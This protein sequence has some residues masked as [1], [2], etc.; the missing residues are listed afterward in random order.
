[1]RPL[2]SL[3][4]LLTLSLFSGYTTKAAEPSALAEPI[5]S[6]QYRKESI[7]VILSVSETNIPTS[8]KVQLMLD[9]HAPHDSEVFFP[10]I[11]PF[12]EPFAI[13]NGYAEPVQLLP[14]GKQLHRRVWELVP[15]LPGET[16]FQ[17]LE[18]QIGA[19]A[20]TTEPVAVNVTSLLPAE[21]S[22]LE[23]RD[24]SAPIA[25]LPKQQLKREWILKTIASLIGILLIG[26]VFKFR[27]RVSTIGVVPPYKAALQSLENLPDEELEKIHRLVEILLAFIGKRFQLPITGRTVDEI[28]PLLS[29]ETLGE[30]RE[31]LETFIRAG[32]QIRFS[33]KV[34][35]D[36]AASFE[37]YV[38]T[39]IEEM[40]EEPCD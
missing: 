9:V 16:I 11:E 32:E 31:Q 40:K 34:P 22:I 39:F 3:C 24:I 17:P 30:N 13:A 38:R 8:G 18:I 35:S 33:N 25:L 4:L 36:F 5:F 23:I 6:Q 19:T 28:L 2:L 29:P 12:I 7:T 37:N 27:K 14:S 1:M 20:I 26:L 21:I 15:N 10:E